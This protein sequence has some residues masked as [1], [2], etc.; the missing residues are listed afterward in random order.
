MLYKIFLFSNLLPVIAGLLQWKKLPVTLRI[1]S[2]IPL[3]DFSAE[4]IAKWSAHTFQNNM[5]VFN[6]YRVIEVFLLS[7]FFYFLFPKEKFKRVLTYGSAILILFGLVSSQW[8]SGWMTYNNP[9]FVLSSIWYILL[10]FMYYLQLLDRFPIQGLER[11]PYFVINTALIIYFIVSALAF[12]VLILTQKMDQN[13][14]LLFK[15]NHIFRNVLIATGLLLFAKK[16]IKQK[17][18]E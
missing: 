2:L 17:A 13:L 3:A 12:A 1:I 7:L 15:V 14:W 9:F 8:I 6:G 11:D 16:W 5:I 18:Y 4:I 10:A